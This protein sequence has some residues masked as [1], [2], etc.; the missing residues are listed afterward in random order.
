M[1]PRR[2][3]SQNIR[4]RKRDVPELMDEER[5]SHRPEKLRRE[6]EVIILDPCHRS[7]GASFR[8]VGDGV[9][10]AEI[11]GAVSL[12]V[13]RPKLEM[14]DEHVTQR[15]E[16]AIRE[17]AVVALDVRFV[18]PHPMESVL[19]ILGRHLHASRFIAHSTIGGP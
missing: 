18:E 17:A 5:R 14:L 10:E 2:Q 13:F 19:R 1:R 4:R 9:C 15:P 8:F 11:Y 6:R 16:R 3:Q 12:P 7:A